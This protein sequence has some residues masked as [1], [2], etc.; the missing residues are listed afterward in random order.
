MM[1]RNSM[2]EKIAI[3]PRRSVALYALLSI[4]MVIV[5]Y[6]FVIA[7]AAACVYLP[8]LI[9]QSVEHPQAQLAILFLGGILIAGAMLWSLVPRREKFE[10]PGTPL[11][12]DTHPLLFA[13]LDDIAGS[14]NEALPG[15][16]YLIGQVNAFVAD[17]GGILGF[18]SRR[19]MAVGLPLLSVLNISEFRGV[20]A[21]EFGHYYSGDTSI[22][23]W[24]YK[25]QAAMIR[26]FRSI[27]SLQ[28]I[29]VGA[30]QLMYGLISFLIKQY[31]VGFL[32]VVNFV[33]RKKEHRADELACLV[34]GS[35]ACIQGMR[36]IHVGGMAWMPYWNSEVLPVL[37]Q[38]CRP[39]IADGFARF[40]AA[41]EIAAQVREGIENEIAEGKTNPYD[42]HP[43]LRD[44]IAAIAASTRS[45][46]RPFT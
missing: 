9:V 5:S 30:I 18:G 1:A 37:E 17:R 10:P 4:A 44:R 33:S 13:E 20:V 46:V 45:C 22:G 2:R 34:A 6:I 40:L 27:G 26:T 41:P 42:T 24:V 32:R 14:L 43:P 25:T 36:K 16:V 38:G 8:Y 31:F 19:I 35:A 39:D 3:T 7:L 29:R 23:P 11:D 28:G 15:E 21:H 12:R